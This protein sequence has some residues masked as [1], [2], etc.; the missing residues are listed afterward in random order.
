M[1]ELTMQD[2]DTQL[3]EPLPARELMGH[4]SR[5]GSYSNAEAGNESSANG[6]IAVNA[7][8]GNQVQVLTFGSNNGNFAEAG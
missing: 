2:L 3:A 5:S 8:N 6:L 1:R 4:W 7:L